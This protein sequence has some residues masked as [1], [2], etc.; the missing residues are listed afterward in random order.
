[1]PTATVNLFN[2]G[3]QSLG[4]QINGG[5]SV[6]I[7]ATG[8]NVNWLPQQPTTNQPTFT[9]GNPSPNAFGYGTNQLIVTVGTSPSSQLVSIPID[10]SMNIVSLQVYMWW[11]TSDSVSWVAMNAGVMFQ[12]GTVSS[13]KAV[14]AAL[15][16]V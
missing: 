10:K 5:T 2:A 12:Q 14:Q 3:P 7:A 13:A 8:A 9:G 1:M 15:A 6:A 16:A 4:M 11:G